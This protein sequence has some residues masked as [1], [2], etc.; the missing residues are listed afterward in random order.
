[1]PERKQEQTTEETV[2][3]NIVECICTILKKATKRLK[4]WKFERKKIGIVVCIQ[5]YGNHCE[6]IHIFSV[7]L[8]TMF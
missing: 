5:T 6:L 4:G 2:T 7:S 1:M 3:V 8:Y